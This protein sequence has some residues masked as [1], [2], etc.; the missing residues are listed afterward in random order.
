MDSSDSDSDIP[1]AEAY[2]SAS[3]EED[4]EKGDD[5]NS[6]FVAKCAHKTYDAAG[7]KWTRDPFLA[8]M[9]LPFDDVRTPAGQKLQSEIGCFK[10]IISPDLISM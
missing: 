4:Y 8:V 1:D 9:D 2:E 6:S 7:G 5:R 10:T 3:D